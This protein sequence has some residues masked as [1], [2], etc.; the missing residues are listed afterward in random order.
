MQ[1]LTPY[2]F[3]VRGVNN[4]IAGAK[5][6]IALDPALGASIIGDAPD[7]PGYVVDI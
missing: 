6:L 7:L 4:R 1:D 3:R 5:V 2:F